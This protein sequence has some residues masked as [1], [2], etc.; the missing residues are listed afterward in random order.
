MSLDFTSAERVLFLGEGNF[1]FSASLIQKLIAEQVIEDG[2]NVTV[3]CYEP[4]CEPTPSLRILAYSKKTKLA[5][6]R[7]FFSLLEFL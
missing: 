4:R 3:T 1:S 2:R 5:L 7:V 6:L